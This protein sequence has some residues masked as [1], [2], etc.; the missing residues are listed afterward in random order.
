MLVLLPAVMNQWDDFNV[1][2]SAYWADAGWSQPDKI[3]L[4]V[5]LKN[6]S[7]IPGSHVFAIS[8]INELP[9]K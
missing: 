1:D 3:D 7:S 9:S 4:Y 8:S 2:I 6:D 5:M